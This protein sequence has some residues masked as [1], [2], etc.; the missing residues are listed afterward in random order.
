M[1]VAGIAAAGRVGEPSGAAAWALLAGMVVGLAVFEGAVVGVAQWAVLREALLGLAARSWVGAT[2]VGAVVAWLLGMI[3]SSLAAAGETSAVPAPEP[4]PGVVA[5]LAAAMG[6]VLGVV[7]ATAQW[8]ILRRHLR[9][10]LLWLAGNALAWAVAMPLIFWL[11][12]ATVAET[13]TLRS[14]TLLVLG[15]G[16]AGAVVGAV[17]GLFLLRLLSWR[18]AG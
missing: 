3:P 4:A 15:I 17:H 2:V 11:V 6:A 9:R 5:A 10:A 8:W 14:A 13:R 18:R 16:A 7:L 1:F 12:G